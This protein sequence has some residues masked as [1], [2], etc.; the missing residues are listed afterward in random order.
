MYTGKVIAL[1]L[2]RKYYKLYCLDLGKGLL[3]HP[4]LNGLASRTQDVQVCVHNDSL[5][6]VLFPLKK[7]TCVRVT[8]NPNRHPG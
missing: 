3:F 4:P 2:F 8:Q 1:S 7:T 5:G 6:F